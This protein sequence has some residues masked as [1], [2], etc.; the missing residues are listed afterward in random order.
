ME[1]SSNA[2]AVERKWRMKTA[3]LIRESKQILLNR[4]I[5]RF[6]SLLQLAVDTGKLDRET[7]TPEQEREM[8]SKVEGEWGRELLST[9]DDDA[10]QMLLSLVEKVQFFDNLVERIRERLRLPNRQER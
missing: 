2:D 6:D 7:I 8:R 3:A 1:Q 10:L 9:G 4:K 5:E